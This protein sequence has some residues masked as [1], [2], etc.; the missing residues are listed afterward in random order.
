MSANLHAL[1]HL[2]IGVGIYVHQLV[3]TVDCKKAGDRLSDH[4][5]ETPSGRSR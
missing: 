3:N 4:L 2:E 5:M 1:R